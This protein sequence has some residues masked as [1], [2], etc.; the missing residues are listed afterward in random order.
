MSNHHVYTLVTTLKAHKSH[1]TCL[2]ISRFWILTATSLPSANRAQCTCATLADARAVLSMTPF[3]SSPAKL[4]PNISSTL[5][6]KSSRITFSTSCHSFC[7]ASSN[8][9]LNIFWNSGGR[10]ALCI[11][12]A[13]PIFK[14]S[15][16]FDRSSSKTR[17]ALRACS[18]SIDGASGGWARKLIL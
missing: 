11:A 3:P 1:P 5:L 2:A 12:I 6:P 14:Y 16:P 15:P 4:T 13:W 8:I 9:L 18:A 10:I 7:G 17:S